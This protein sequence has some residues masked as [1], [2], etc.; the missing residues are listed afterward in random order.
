MFVYCPTPTH[1]IIHYI[2]YSSL[3]CG[4]KQICQLIALP[5]LGW[6]EELWPKLVTSAVDQW[7]RCTCIGEQCFW[8]TPCWQSPETCAQ[9]C[10]VYKQHKTTRHSTKHSSSA[11]TWDGQ[12]GCSWPWLMLKSVTHFMA[13]MDQV[14]GR[15]R[16]GGV[17][18]YTNQSHPSHAN[19]E[20]GLPH[21]YG[22][23]SCH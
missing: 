19:H 22:V 4:N 5:L 6:N 21:L 3:Q 1:I 16:A 2:L 20:P 12:Q 13:Q 15:W 23:E 8:C 11:A 17:L 10:M 9:T 18:L 14:L 7:S